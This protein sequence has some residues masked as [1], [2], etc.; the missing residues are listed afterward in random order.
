MIKNTVKIINKNSNTFINIRN[1]NYTNINNSLKGDFC[2]TK[3][4][5]TTL[6][7]NN[8]NRNIQTPISINTTTINETLTSNNKNNDFNV[9]KFSTIS[10]P[11]SILDS[12]IQNPTSQNNV[13]NNNNI[14]SDNIRTPNHQNNNKLDLDT[15]KLYVSKS[16]SEL[17]FTFMI[18]K[19]CSFNFISDNS[20]NF[21]NLFEKLGLSKPLNFFIKYSF[22]KQFCA[23]ETIRE[24]EIFTEKLNK[25]GIGTILDYAIE[26]LA[27]S[28][29]GFDS[30]AENVCQTIRVAA[31]NP[32]NSFSCVKFTGLVTPSVLEKMNNLVSS[33]ATNVSELPTE[34]FNSPLDF[35]LNQSLKQSDSTTSSLTNNDIK[36]MKEFFNRMDKIFKLCHECSVPILVDAEQSYYQ[37]AIHH[38]AMSY[39]IKYNKDRPI[40]YNTYQMYLANG[41]N[42]LKQHFNLS[43]KL[44]FKLGAKIVRGAYMVTESERSQRLSIENPILPTIQDT[45][46]SYNTALDFLLNK[47]RLDPKSIGIMIASHNEDSI[48]LGTKLIKQYQIDPTNPNIQFGQLF[49]MA[50]FLSFN[51]VSQHQRIFKYV[52]FGP[53]QEVLPYLIR[54]MHENKGF[55]GSNSDKELFYLKKEIKRRLF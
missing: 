21:L 46:N 26:E 5:N 19:V 24:T 6:N 10:T 8:S 48:N 4:F 49:G 33:V 34:S 40:L 27:G 42:V 20:Q 31:K 41:M 45:H 23:G 12:L 47:I 43:E 53:V 36:E 14:D 28:S 37:V 32:T 25:L 39:S 51:L 18:L 35:Y 15:S 52:P 22:F 38:L 29:E 50:D 1:N 55:I 7:H 11:N 30:V 54:R 2:T 16:T 44:G 17:F 13:N 9:V 3:R